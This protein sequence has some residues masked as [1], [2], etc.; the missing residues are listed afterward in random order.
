MEQDIMTLLP[1]CRF[2]I[3]PSRRAAGLPRPTPA[4]SRIAAAATCALA[5]ALA[6]ARA[7]GPYRNG[8]NP[9]L[10][11]PSEG[12]YPVPY[13]LPSVAEITADLERVRGFLEASVP[14]RII[15]RRTR[16]PIDPRTKPVAEAVAD[17]GDDEDFYNLDYTM[18][19][20][21][22][23][24]LRAADATGDPR[25]AEF[26]AHQLRFIA[27]ALPYFRAQ[28]AAFGGAAHTSFRA[29]L[30]PAALDDCG[31]MTAALVKARLA[32]VGPDLRG[33]IDR[34]SGYIARGQFRLADG[35][36]A[37][38]RPQA[39]SVWADDFYMAVPALAQMGRLTGERAWYDDAVRNARQMSARLVR[40][41]TGLFA[42]G[43]IAAN[44]AA[45]PFYWARANGWAMMA[46]C[47]L[48]DAL[49]P[50]HPGRAGVLATLRT[51][52]AAVAAL[53]SGRGLWHQM[54]DRNDSFLETSASA[55]FVYGIAHAVNQGWISPATYGS[56][57]QAGW[58]GVAAQINPRGQ[59]EN[60]CVGTTFAAD[61]TYYY[62][63]PVSPYALHG[64]GPVLLAG[65]EMIRLRTNPA[66]EIQYRTRTY[67]YVPKP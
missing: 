24:M 44:P 29:V 57:A 51:Q 7:E 3:L 63:R 26:T 43:W 2:R 55:M 19:V 61:Q 28:A 25:F 9:N 49:P 16:R 64:Y 52:I 60:T 5:V 47:E 37:R 56:I 58:I 31:A 13:H 27:D 54:V 34:W 65:A 48:L 10:H 36:L 18:G 38:R 11:D 21:H 6:P 15:D 40:P 41:E 4:A 35:T 1:K 53:Q 67:F 46:M 45:P 22:A 8:D 20:V 59:V 12:T 39:E 32:G 14:A 30:E 33:V 50:D 17:R 66:F 62:H 42:H 23:G